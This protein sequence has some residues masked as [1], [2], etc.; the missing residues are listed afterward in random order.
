VRKTRA[1]AGQASAGAMQYSLHLDDGPEQRERDRL[2]GVAARVGGENPDLWAN[3][4]FQEFVWC[5]D[6]MRDTIIK[7]P[8]Y[9]ARVGRQQ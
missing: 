8:E 5:L 1:E 3:A 4:D 2:I 6:V 7:W 9:L